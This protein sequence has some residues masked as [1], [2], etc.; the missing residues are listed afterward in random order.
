MSPKKQKQ[1]AD[2]TL[3]PAPERT[4]PIVT[5]PKFKPVTIIRDPKL[6][7]PNDIDMVILRPML[8]EVK[9]E[10]TNPSKE[11]KYGLLL[12]MSSRY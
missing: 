12:M 9:E 2:A 8:S 6:A 7:T 4:T 11:P 5:I 10:M 1:S 3:I